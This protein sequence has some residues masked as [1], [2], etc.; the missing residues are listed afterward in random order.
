MRRTLHIIKLERALSLAL[1][2]LIK[3]EHKDSRFVSDEFVALAAVDAKIDDAA[4]WR[5]I[6]AAL[7]TT[8][9]EAI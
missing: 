6:N 9:K 1:T 3:Y 5:V 4:S 8:M 7:A 2:M